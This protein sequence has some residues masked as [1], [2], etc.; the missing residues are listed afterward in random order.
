MPLFSIISSQTVK[1]YQNREK[2]GY[3]ANNHLV[4]GFIQNT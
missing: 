1:I 3:E 2:G 4:D